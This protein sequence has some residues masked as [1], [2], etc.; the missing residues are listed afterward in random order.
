M[1]KVT[2]YIETAGK[3]R[4]VSLEDEL[5]LGRTGAAT[6]ALDD[7]GLSRVNTTI[8]RDG[9]IVYVVDENSL[10]GTF[11][12]GQKLGANPERLLD[13]DVLTL[14]SETK[15][16]V[17]FGQKETASVASGSR[18][19]E[20]ASQKPSIETPSANP[21]SQIPNPKSNAPPMVLILAVGSAFF[22]I[23]VALIGVFIASRYENQP[24]TSKG[25][26]PPKI[27]TAAVIP[28]RVRDPFG[29]QSPEDLQELVQYWEVQE[30]DV[31]AADLQDITVSSDSAGK[32]TATDLKVSVEF[33][34][35][36]KAK[37]L[38]ARSSPTGNDPPGTQVP[39]ELFGDGVIKQKAKLGEMLRKGY[40]Q[41][42]DF[43]ELAQK[44]L[45]GELV[46]LPMATESYIVEVGGSASEAEFTS[47]NF[48][49]PS[50][51]IT[52]GSAK[53]NTLQQLANNFAG[54]KYDLNNPSHRKQMR[55]RLLRMFHPRARPILER[56]A[57]AY[58]AKFNRPLR[59]TSLSRSMDYQISLNRVNPNSFVV[60][61]PGS[62]PPHTS[63][64]AFDLARKH[65]TAEEQN[66]VMAELAQME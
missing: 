65:M 45:S 31:E 33:W 58:H 25:K 14:G 42:M 21:K 32:E 39:R 53:Y 66:F 8:F 40:Q 9:E 48:A 57:K 35:Q 12:N 26:T 51:P 27:N 50:A 18:Q 22:I 1:Q 47:F 20:T 54:E 11:L 44:R 34:Q 37:A 23:F 7:T 59:L 24:K 30:E 29:G 10:N 2:L 17:E 36:Q 56:L 49:A 28:I 46:E 19:S 55:I 38:A 52:P 63:G 15:V 13:D 5:S 3:S 16:R 61:G 62:L 6:V 43:A 64:C 60:R 41:P 4:T